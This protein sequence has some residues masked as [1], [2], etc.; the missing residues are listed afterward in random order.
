[1]KTFFS[2]L[3]QRQTQHGFQRSK[4]GLPLTAANGN[5]GSEKNLRTTLKQKAQSLSDYAQQDLSVVTQRPRILDMQRLQVISQV[6]LINNKCKLAT[7][8]KHASISI[9]IF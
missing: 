1:M 4:S 6:T 2:T 3:H 5:A 9:N 8:A 7:Y